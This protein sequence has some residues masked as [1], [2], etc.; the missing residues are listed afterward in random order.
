MTFTLAD[1][2][3]RVG[4]TPGEPWPNHAWPGAYV[5]S[6]YTDDGE[7]LCGDC[8]DNEHEVVHFDE[9]NDGWRIIGADI[10]EET[11][12]DIRCAHC[13]VLMMEAYTT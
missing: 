6:Y 12:T 3:R 8:M 10:L 2:E 1:C 9:P 13:D 4:R 7:S 5:I 11:E